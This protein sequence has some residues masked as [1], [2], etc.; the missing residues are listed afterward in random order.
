[1]LLAGL[2]FFIFGGTGSENV[3]K[4]LLPTSLVLPEKSKTVSMVKVFLLKD[5]DQ[6]SMAVDTAYQILDAKDLKVL[7][8]G[9]G[10]QRIIAR[11]AGNGIEWNGT[12]YPAER[13][14]LQTDKGHIELGKRRYR[15]HLHVLKSPSGKLAV[16]NEIGIE[17]YLKGVLPL[18]V[19]PDWPAETL[20]AQAVASR[21]YALFQSMKN[22]GSEAALQATVLSQVYG[23][24]LFHKAA[25]D[26][27][28]E[29][30]RGEVLTSA[31]AI[32]PAYFHACCGGRTA[33]PDQIWPLIPNPALAS[34]RCPFCRTAKHYKW[35]LRLSLSSIEAK[36]QANG[37]PAKGLNQ[38]HWIDQDV[39]GRARRV[40]LGYARSDVT[41]SA[42][43]FRRF[44]GV[45]RLRSL[46]ADVTVKDGRASFHGY[47]WG[48]GIGFCQWGAKK[49]AEIG[50][51]Y[52]TILRYYY[53][54]SE[55]E[56]IN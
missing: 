37:F 17:E 31:G 16:M 51:D 21:T 28:V 14:L 8:E 13:I 26:R 5:A 6:V 54:T 52:R 15:D 36:M 45:D 56:K 39:S 11:P 46:K 41:V 4:Q 32:F 12:V 20:K 55:I 22:T 34:V 42:D 10:P 29:E 19:H 7:K 25:T 3:P 38:I 40:A 23:G 27:A 18:E 1:M 43:D 47:G 48:H 30:T 53:P 50:K 44:L 49:Q 9:A 2:F 33:Q 35:A 24:A